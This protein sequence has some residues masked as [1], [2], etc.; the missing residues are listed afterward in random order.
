VKSVT[1][2]YLDKAEVEPRRCQTQKVL[3]G[4]GYDKAGDIGALGRILNILSFY[5][6]LG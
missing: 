3:I 6:L 4:Q 1:L 5:I 2:P